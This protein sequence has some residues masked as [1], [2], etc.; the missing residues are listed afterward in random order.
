MPSISVH[1]PTKVVH[2]YAN[3]F[4][5]MQSLQSHCPLCT[6][7]ESS[8]VQ[9]QAGRRP[10]VLQCSNSP[11]Q[12]QAGRRPAVLQFFT[13]C[14]TCK[15]NV[16]LAWGAPKI[17]NVWMTCPQALFIPPPNWF[18][19]MQMSA[20]SCR[21]IV[22][23]AQ[24]LTFLDAPLLSSRIFEINALPV[25]MLRQVPP[26]SGPK[27]DPGGFFSCFFVVFLGSRFGCAFLIDF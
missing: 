18:I 6:A 24:P 11:V 4:T 23:Y 26:P 21:V 17:P 20:L 22:H 13:S 25:P 7:L 8:P 27:I 19:V 12:H 3:V 9:H 10:A 2:Y 14:Y 5:L 15:D 16:E 1:S